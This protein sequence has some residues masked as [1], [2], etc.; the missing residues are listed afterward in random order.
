MVVV[1]EVFVSSTRTGS[2]KMLP[3]NITKLS[4]SIHTTTRFVVI[5][6]SIGSV[7]QS[8]NTVNYVDLHPQARAHVASEKDTDIPRQLVDHVVLRGAERI[9]FTCVVIVNFL[10]LLLYLE[11]QKI[12]WDWKKILMT[13]TMKL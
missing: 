13:N 9:A 5:Q 7:R 8:T 2:D 10:G 6:K 3:T 4:W 11:F 1:W 12:L